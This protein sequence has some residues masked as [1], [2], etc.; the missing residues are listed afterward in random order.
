MAGTSPS[1]PA[2]NPSEFSFAKA[3]QP[4]FFTVLS[5]SKHRNVNPWSCCL[6]IMSLSALYILL[7]PGR[8]FLIISLSD[9]SLGISSGM[10]AIVSR[11]VF[12]GTSTNSTPNRCFT[13]ST[14]AQ[15]EISQSEGFPITPNRQPFIFFLAPSTFS[16][17]KIRLVIYSGL[18]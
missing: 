4:V 17:S 15:L 12:I 2:T 10:A 14:S 9:D 7:A 11:S 16:R 5:K 13:T 1:Q 18:P 6:S 8:D 3:R